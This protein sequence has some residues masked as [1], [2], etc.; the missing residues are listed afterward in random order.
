MTT[1]PERPAPVDDGEGATQHG[2]PLMDAAQGRGDGDQG[3][4]HGLPAGGEGAG[5]AAAADEQ[6]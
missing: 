1:Q 6:G 4:R 2:D 5:D 3:T